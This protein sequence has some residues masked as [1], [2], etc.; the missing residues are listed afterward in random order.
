[1]N[2]IKLNNGLSLP[3]L[4]FGTY[5]I[6]DEEILDKLLPKAVDLGYELLDTA[7]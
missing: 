5:K 4:G 1:M 3:Q 2:K 6:T 7:S